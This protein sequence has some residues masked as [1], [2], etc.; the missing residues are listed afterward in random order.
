LIGGT[1]GIAP[2]ELKER[3]TLRELAQ[4]PWRRPAIDV[5]L[6]I[7]GDI[8]GRRVGMPRVGATI[9]HGTGDVINALIDHYVEGRP[10][11][12]STRAIIVN[13]VLDY[14]SMLGMD[15]A[16]DFLPNIIGATEAGK[17]L[18]E[19]VAQGLIAQREWQQRV[20]QEAVKR[21]IEA[22]KSG[23]SML[24]EAEP[25]ARKEA[26][27]RATGV[28]EEQAGAA[29]MPKSG[30]SP[31]GEVKGPLPVELQ[32]QKTARDTYYNIVGR[33]KDAYGKMYDKLL[34][35][36]T[37][38]ELPDAALKPQERAE[39]LA[40]VQKAK[41]LQVAYKN[42]EYLKGYKG[43]VPRLIAMTK[44][45]LHEPLSPEENDIITGGKGRVFVS[46]ADKTLDEFIETP[47]DIP[48]VGTMTRTPKKPDTV[49]YLLALLRFSRRAA[50][51]APDAVSAEAAESI[52]R[53]YEDALEKAGLPRQKLIDLKALNQDYRS[54][55]LDFTRKIGSDVSGGQNVVDISDAYFSHP[56]TVKRLLDNATPAEKETLKENFGL[57]GFRYP[58][59]MVPKEAYNNPALAKQLADAYAQINPDSILGNPKGLMYVSGELNNMAAAPNKLNEF[60]QGAMEEFQRQVTQG[61]IEDKKFAIPLLRKLGPVG[62]DVLRKVQLAKTP[63]EAAEI[64]DKFFSSMDQKTLRKL[65]GQKETMGLLGGQLV[66]RQMGV[67]AQP[68]EAAP[69]SYL[70]R[71]A[72][73]PGAWPWYVLTAILTGAQYGHPSGYF[74]MLSAISTPLALRRSFQG[75]IVKGLASDNWRPILS[76]LSNGSYRIMGNQIVRGVL[77]DT[78]TQ[79]MKKGFTVP[80]TEIEVPGVG[81]PL[82]PEP[83][84]EPK[85]FDFGP[86]SQVIERK[87]AQQ[88]ATERGRQDPTHVD[89]IQELNKQVATGAT[90]DIH[91][92]LSTGR[93]SN[94]EVARMLKDRPSDPSAFFQD[95]NLPD[96]MEAFAK[97]TPDEK[98]L[99]L[100]ALAQKIQNE[101]K[102]MQPAQRRAV[103]AQLQRALGED[104]A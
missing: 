99:T 64:A 72:T 4:S 94:T 26:L 77:R 100:A 89:Q 13:G 47:N 36:Y 95:M 33:V 8:A 9:G 43:D 14:A 60:A 74:E 45:L 11:D 104:A 63:E 101:G 82:S 32:K 18:D 52:G 81:D 65:I 70:A 31:G 29:M 17:S 92:D 98:S 49:G 48:G 5:P 3:T 24:E 93:L 38:I 55:N 15:K 28:T 76:S 44:K 19:G 86:M 30:V 53:A 59:K 88:I 40:D 66:G 90:P 37:K 35:D 79:W 42:Q 80:G 71:M 83:D 23:R 39:I 46:D 69:M 56:Q 97:G 78:A 67:V 103:M 6:T 27:T 91:Q 62:E 61:A 7:G 12:L 75:L 85:S 73:K 20:R 84:V 58:T 87:Q 1:G 41:D 2:P 25:G 21:G 57:W 22:E 68:G 50:A 54:M 102:D 34:G 10:I 16:I 51:N 96:A